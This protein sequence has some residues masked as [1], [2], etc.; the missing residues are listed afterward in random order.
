[1]SEFA[2]EIEHLSAADRNGAAQN[3]TLR[4]AKGELFA[5]LGDADGGG[6]ALF[7]ALI[8]RLPMEQGAVYLNGGEVR[9]RKPSAA[10]RAGLGWIAR[11]GDLADEH[12]VLE[13]LTLLPCMGGSKR[14]VREKK[15]STVSR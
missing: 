15:L 7:D 8:G 13:H 1:M 10:R 3:L 9:V 5:V 2:L 12:T 4:A 11:E 14:R 6:S